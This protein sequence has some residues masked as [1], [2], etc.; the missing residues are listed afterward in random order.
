MINNLVD[1]LITRHPILLSCKNDILLFCKVLIE[2]FKNGGKVLVCGNGGSSADAGHIVGE[3]MKS[4]RKPRPTS[5]HEKLQLPLRAIDLTAQN[6][7]VTAIANDIGAE[8]VFSQQVLGYADKDDVFIGISTTGN[9]SN[10]NNAAEL[11]N[12]LGAIS[13]GL[14][15]GDG[16]ELKNICNITVCVQ[17]NETYRVQEEHLAIYHTVCMVVE[18]E[19]FRES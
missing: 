15:G 16:G 17:E 4:F 9:S 1:D 10:V 7:L 12:K 18:E 13:I 11:A 8:H 3:L 14:T 5:V 19:I 2:C 6:T